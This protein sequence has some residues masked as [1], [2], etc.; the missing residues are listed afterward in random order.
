MQAWGREMA[1][2][3]IAVLHAKG[4][5]VL[6]KMRPGKTVRLK[7]PAQ[8]QRGGR[9][10]KTIRNAGPRAGLEENTQ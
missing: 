2:K 9:N 4:G 1:E 3:L 10:E 6:T 5:T 8:G 7:T